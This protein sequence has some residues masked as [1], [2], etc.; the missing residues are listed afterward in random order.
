MAESQE[1]RARTK[2]YHLLRK[3]SLYIPQQEHGYTE[4]LQLLRKGNQQKAVT[5][6]HTTKEVPKSAQ[7]E[8]KQSGEQAERDRAKAY[9]KKHA[10]RE[11]TLTVQ[12]SQI[13]NSASNRAPTHMRHTTKRR[14]STMSPVTAADEI[15]AHTARAVDA[16]LATIEKL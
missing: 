15:A 10:T 16:A 9:Y 7:P 14:H 12:H 4:K 1:E 2:V 3:N 13:R 5:A 8:T 6:S 11:P